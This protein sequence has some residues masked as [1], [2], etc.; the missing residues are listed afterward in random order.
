MSEKHN[1]EKEDL[2]QRIEN[3]EKAT[4][5]NSRLLVILVWPNWD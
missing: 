1:Q 5:T 4:I 2:I 3:L